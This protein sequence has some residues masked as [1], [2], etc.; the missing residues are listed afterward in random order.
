MGK[1]KVG[2]HHTRV[3]ELKAAKEG[4]IASSERTI[5]YRIRSGIKQVDAITGGLDLL[6]LE[7]EFGCAFA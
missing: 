1:W 2:R 7:R 6:Q 4:Q 5:L 3:K